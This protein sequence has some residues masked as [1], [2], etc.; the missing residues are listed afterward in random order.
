MNDFFNKHF[1]KIFIGFV[2]VIFVLPIIAPIF[3]ILGLEFF[4]R[5][6]YW[7]YSFSCHQLA[8]RSLHIRDEQCAWCTRDTFIW[9]GIL[10]AAILVPQLNI[11]KFRIYWAIPF[12]IPIALDGGIQ[13]IATMLGFGGG[14]DFYTSTNFM[15]AVTGGIFGIGMGLMLGSLVYNSQEMEIRSRLTRFLK[16]FKNFKILKVALL[17]FIVLMIFYVFMIQLWDKTSNEYKPENALDLAVRTPP[18]DEAWTRQ[19]NGACN[20]EK[21]KNIADGSSFAD[22][23]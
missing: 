20:P 8:H 15:R 5:P 9:G 22:V 11:K 19:I 3:T 18:G 2:L 21:P 4:S 12:V 7:L 6:I 1:Y 10:L 13:T 17:V 16:Y 14:S 23:V